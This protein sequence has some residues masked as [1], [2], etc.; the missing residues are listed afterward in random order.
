[1]GNVITVNL[2]YG[3]CRTEQYITD[4]KLYQYDYGQILKLTGIEL[5]ELYEVHFSNGER[6]TS[7]TGI[8]TTDG[9]E[10]PDQYLLN[11]GKLYVWL[12]THTTEDDGETE[13]GFWIPIIPRAQPTH[14]TPTPVQ[15]TEIERLIALAEEIVEHG[16]GS[17]GGS[18]GF[19]PIV[20]VTEIT[21][22][23]RLSIQDKTHTA[24][25]YKHSDDEEP[26]LRQYERESLDKLYASYETLGGN[27]FVQDLYEQMRHWKVIT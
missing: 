27:S 8:G 10:I 4:Q 6:G 19:S 25:Y 13:L 18:D 15:Q 24:T 20:T 26:T 7:T 3:C 11:A 9:V 1:M 21:G 22:G 2:N 16:G 14:E 12:Y 23:H 17:G 5:P